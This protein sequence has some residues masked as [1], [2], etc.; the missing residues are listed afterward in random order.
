MIQD[1]FNPV[2]FWGWGLNI[3]TPHPTSP[4]SRV[5]P[6]VF[7]SLEFFNKNIG[8]TNFFNPI[9]PS[10]SMINHRFLPKIFWTRKFSWP[11]LFLRSK[12]FQPKIIRI[13]SFLLFNNFLKPNNLKDFSPKTSD[14]SLSKNLYLI[15]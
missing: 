8:G 5:N 14:R 12:L 9:D 4:A 13:Q 11:K 1:V 10:L 6:L 2:I 7:S 15:A 3:Q